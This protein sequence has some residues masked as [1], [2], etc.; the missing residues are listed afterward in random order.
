VETLPDDL[1]N[2]IISD[3]DEGDNAMEEES[4]DLAIS[5]YQQALE[6]VPAPKH[7][8]EISFNIYTAMADTYFNMHDFENAV[9]CYNQALQCPDGT[10]NGYVWLGLGQSYLEIDETEKAIDALFSAWMLEGEEIF[11]G[12]NQEY[13]QLIK[14]K[15]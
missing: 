13:F 8:W 10:V 9:Y 12:D 15:I 2:A 5:F 3:M 6:K 11:D 1:Y 4:C 7:D 14:D